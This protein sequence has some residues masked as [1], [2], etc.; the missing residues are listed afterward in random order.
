VGRDGPLQQSRGPESFSPSNVDSLGTFVPWPA[1]I[2]DGRRAPIGGRV[3]EAEEAAE[4]GRHFLAAAGLA[5]GV[6]ARLR[7]AGAFT[8]P[9][10]PIDRRRKD[11]VTCGR[12]AGGGVAIA[13]PDIGPSRPQSA[14]VVPQGGQAPQA[15]PE[16]VRARTRALRCEIRRTT[17]VPAQAIVRPC[18]G[19]QGVRKGREGPRG[20]PVIR[21]PSQPKAVLGATGL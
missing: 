4:L 16:P 9:W 3:S 19:G 13:T 6:A 20:R 1:V 7:E 8:S 10:G 18:T 15:C 21:A 2:W 12:G 14:P 5:I 11:G 17:F